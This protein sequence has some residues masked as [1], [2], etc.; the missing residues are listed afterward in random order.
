MNLIWFLTI[1][2]ILS[3]SLGEFGQFPFGSPVSVSL[4]DILLGLNLSLFFIWKIGIEKKLFLPKEFKILTLFWLLGFV[5]LIFSGFGGILYLVRFIFYSLSFL[6]GFH[7][8]SDKRI[9]IFDLLRVFGITGLII[10]VLGFLQLIILPN[11]DQLSLLGYDPHQNRLTSTFLDPNFAAAILVFMIGIS[12]SLY[13]NSLRKEWLVIIPLE[14]IGFALTFSRSGYLMFVVVFGLLSILKEKRALFLAIP[15]ILLSLLIPQISQRIIGGLTLD[16]SA[17]DRLISWQNGLNVFVKNPIFG[18][19]FDNLRQFF[20]KNNLI[21]TY[22]A[23][24]GNSGSGV[25]SSFIFVMATTG[26]CGL[27]TYL[28][29][30]KEILFK[31]F[32]NS[33]SSQVLVILGCLY[34][35]LFI[36]SQFINSLF[37]PPIMLMIYLTAGSLVALNT[38]AKKD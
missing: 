1:V 34:I 5:G 33:R 18:V 7:L 21:Q 15:L 19:G 28:W 38:G 23:S 9:N 27:F 36:N 30:W 20:V 31:A 35:G 2:T 16:S 11:F 17:R 13:L 10:V 24:G 6:I 32:K 4:T 22:T 8:I 14:I 12:L 29:W 37:Y 26:I 3:I 25:D